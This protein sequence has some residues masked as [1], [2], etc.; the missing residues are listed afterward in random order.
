MRRFGR[1][2]TILFLVLLLGL[3]SLQL[4]V[5]RPAE[6]AP[7]SH[8]MTHAPILI[9][10]DQDFTAANGVT[11]GSGTQADPYVIE[12]WEID[13][14]TSHGI[15]I[16]DASSSIVIKDVYVHS[17]GAN[18]G[19]LLENISSADLVNVTTTG[20][21]HGIR[22][23]DSSI[24]SIEGAEVASN[25]LGINIVD[26][27]NP[28]IFR[29]NVTLSVGKG[30]EISS[31]DEGDI[32]ENNVTWNAG[33]GLHISN[34]PGCHLHGNLVA[35]NGGYGMNLFSACYSAGSNVVLSNGKGG[36]NAQGLAAMEFHGNQVSRNQG[37]GIRAVS[38]EAIHVEASQVSYNTGTGIVLGGTPNVTVT[39]NNIIDNG[40]QASD[41]RALTWTRDPPGLFHGGNFW[42]DY[43]GKDECSGLNQDICP[44][45][46]GFGDTPYQI[47]D[48]SQ[49]TRPLMEPFELPDVTPPI[50]VHVPLQTAITGEPLTVAASIRDQSS[51]EDT[52]LYYRRAG[53][54]NFNRGWMRI[55]R[56]LTY[57][58]QIPAQRDPGEV[59]YFIIAEDGLGN[60]ARDPPTGMHVVTVSFGVPLHNWI[61]ILSVTAVLL[62]AVVLVY[63]YTRKRPG[64]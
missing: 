58:T 4:T 36:I 18:D 52:A 10:G 30:I 45:S 17:G 16:R 28:L 1:A 7:S 64:V 26:T 32:W 48:D 35:E 2:T 46:D 15:W 9:Q 51:L 61:P 59:F 53:D 47:D 40:V 49:D 14:S 11:G 33:D 21:R 63:Y 31:G 20:N 25:Q 8:Y 24:V 55:T 60:V 57:E 29:S 56:G 43:S 3:A 37:D 44:E 62:A 12:G 13:A 6:A 38:S 19:V 41:D 27:L 50:I 42:S 22:V 5:P 54:A 39:D 34:L 23:A